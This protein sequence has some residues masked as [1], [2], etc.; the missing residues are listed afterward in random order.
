[1]ATYSAAVPPEL[2]MMPLSTASNMHLIYPSKDQHQIPMSQ[3][4]HQATA[5]LPEQASSDFGKLTVVLDIDETLIHAEFLNAAQSAALLNTPGSL[6]ALNA[7]LQQQCCFAFAYK[8]RVA[9]VRKRPFLTEFLAHASSMF[10]LVAF[11]AAEEDYASL[12]IRELDP[13][14]IFFKHKLFRQHCSMNGHVKDLRVVNRRLERTVL[15]DNSHSSF[16]YQLA[17]GIPIESF[18]TDVN[19]KAL[20]TLMDFLR[21]L[22]QEP[23]VR[24]L[25]RNIFRLETKVMASMQASFQMF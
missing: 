4:L 24:T 13:C 5:T 25:L 16:M 7:A 22:R 11:T 8:R 23:D 1:M 2:F 19:D 15:V 18:T 10:E 20:I 12:V 14:G 3:D 6:E 17:N 9:I 21:C